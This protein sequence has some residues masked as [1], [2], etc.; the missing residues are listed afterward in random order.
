MFKVVVSCRGVPPDQGPQL[1]LD[2]ASGFVE[3]TWHSSVQCRWKVDTLELSAVND[4]DS[5]GTALS[6]EFWDE[7][8]A[9]L[10]D[11]FEQ[12]SF[13]IDAVLSMDT[14]SPNMR[15]SGP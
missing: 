4:F 2:V 6:D 7:V 3:R 12:I 14:Q 15:R 1:A 10:G 5:D 13:S 11:G 8:L 9:N